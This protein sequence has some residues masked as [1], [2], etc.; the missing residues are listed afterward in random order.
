[1]VLVEMKNISHGDIGVSR[2]VEAT[3]KPDIEMPIPFSNNN[4]LMASLYVRGYDLPEVAEV[5]GNSPL[6]VRRLFN[7]ARF[8]Q[9]IPHKIAHVQGFLPK[10]AVQSMLW[11]YKH[12]F[13]PPISVMQPYTGEYADVF[14]VGQLDAMGAYLAGYTRQKDIIS[15]VFLSAGT[16]RNYFASGMMS[17]RAEIRDMTADQ[18]AV[19]NNLSAGF[20]MVQHG[21]LPHDIIGRDLP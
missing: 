19:T 4:L 9:S 21:F 14:S 8:V 16:I 13:L 7:D 1:M 15:Q 17:I 18:R 12:K 6:Y 5:L 3:W 10:S 11:M 20:W 2:V